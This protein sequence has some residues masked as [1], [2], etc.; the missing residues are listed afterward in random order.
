MAAQGW[1]GHPSHQCTF[2]LILHRTPAPDV[3]AICLVTRYASRNAMFGPID[4]PLVERAPH[5]VHQRIEQDPGHRAV[6]GGDDRPF[7]EAAN[8]CSTRTVRRRDGWRPIQ[9]TSGPLLLDGRRSNSTFARHRSENAQYSIT[10][11]HPSSS[12]DAEE[13]LLRAPKRRHTPADA[14]AGNHMVSSGRLVPQLGRTRQRTRQFL[15]DSG[16]TRQERRRE[17]WPSPNAQY[18]Q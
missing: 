10:T 14:I 12:I 4:S 15:R 11:A 3:D 13:S 8:S 2:E 9:T 16:G 7:V 6:P 17:W 18:W 1:T 5:V